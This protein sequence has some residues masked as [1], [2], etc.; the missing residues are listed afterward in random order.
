[1]PT[2]T[3]QTLVLTDDSDAVRSRMASAP[4]YYGFLV[5][6]T[7]DTD[8]AIERV[9]NDSTSMVVVDL[10]LAAGDPLDFLDR[11]HGADLDDIVLLVG[12]RSM[13][14][15]Q[16]AVSRGFSSYV[17]K[18]ATEDEWR[19]VF[20][21]ARRQ[22]ENRPLPL[23][24]LGFSAEVQDAVTLAEQA[25]ALDGHVTLVGERGVGRRSLARLI[26]ERS[27][28]RGGA[29]SQFSCAGVSSQMVEQTLFGSMSPTVTGTADPRP[30]LLECSHGGTLLIEDVTYLPKRA[31]DLL[32]R[33]LKVRS[34]RRGGHGA[35]VPLDV[36]VVALSGLPLSDAV[37]SG[38]FHRELADELTSFHA[39][40]PPLRE[41]KLDIP[42]LADHF[43]RRAA[44][45]ARKPVKG[46]SDAALERLMRYDWPGNV[47]ELEHMVVKAVESTTHAWLAAEDLP[48]LPDAVRA[49]TSR[50]PG[51]TIQEIE[52]EAILRTLDAV[53]GSTSRAARVL[54][55][56]VRKIQYKLKEYRK[57]ATATLPSEKVQTVAAGS[58]VRTSRLRDAVFVTEPE[59]PQD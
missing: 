54:N 46:V 51:A 38:Q 45:T 32:L 22:A 56:S 42:V 19:V 23:A 30:G 44:R 26:H 27:P 5:S 55:M 43:V 31:Q 36:R 29:F 35:T 37:G 21:R 59:T 12:E 17:H 6:M 13:H 58:R 52:R 7:S 24:F 10:D 48:A 11:I 20:A 39:V 15:L 16:T 9:E 28:R 57:D 18:S 49:P 3:R 50:V 1:M 41:R 4:S 2:P 40:V 25:A 8:T 34:L 53:G 47:R 14:A 33:A